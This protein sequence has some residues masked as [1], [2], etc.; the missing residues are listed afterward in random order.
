MVLL[1]V[2]QKGLQWTILA[3][4]Y[5]DM[6]SKR[7]VIPTKTTFIVVIV[8]V[9]YRVGV[10]VWDMVRRRK[11]TFLEILSVSVILAFSCCLNLAC[12]VHYNVQE[13]ENYEI[14]L[15]LFLL[16]LVIINIYLSDRESRRSNGVCQYTG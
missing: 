3:D 10:L 15:L 2:L 4:I 13:Y 16:G 12:K 11:I 1:F 14:D 7:L 6:Y 5:E 8:I 9:I